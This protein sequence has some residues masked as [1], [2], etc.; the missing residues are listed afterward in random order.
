[1][2]VILSLLIMPAAVFAAHEV[3]AVHGTVFY[4]ENQDGVFDV[5][6]FG[7]EGVTIE[8]HFHDDPIITTTTDVNGLYEFTGL[9]T[10]DYTVVELDLVDYVS[11]TPNEVDFRVNGFEPVPTVNFGDV[12]AV[13][14]LPGSISGTVY[15]DVD[16]SRDRSSGDLPLAGAT[17]HLWDSDE[18]EF[19]PAVTTDIDGTFSFEDLPQGTYR[20]REDDPD[21]YYSTTPHEVTV[22]IELSNE[23]IVDVN[24][25][26]FVPE[27]GEIKPVDLPIARF[28][29]L[30]LLDIFDLRS[31]DGYGYG[32]IAKLYFISHLSGWEVSEILAMREGTGWGHVMKEVLGKAG[33]KGYNL[34]MIMSGREMPNQVEKIIDGCTLVTTQEDY[35]SLISAGANH[36]Q[37]KKLCKEASSFEELL[38]AFENSDKGK[39]EDKPENGNGPPECKGKN[40]HNEGC[41]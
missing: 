12:S 19:L 7:I 32:N 6:E 39:P 37:I 21:G 16:R 29:D 25:G 17:I 27:P 8:L 36:G 15:N 20:L 24:F 13:D 38:E 10:G 41:D 22:T 11:T 2:I 28:F 26:D 14:I 40:K 23:A 35:Q 33:L 30:P 5:G 1:M 34:G 3:D 18:N 9:G 31:M 4:D